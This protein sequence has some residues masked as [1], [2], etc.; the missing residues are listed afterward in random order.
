MSTGRNS[1][2]PCGSGLKYK[3]C[4]GPKEKTG[5]GSQILMAAAFLIFG[6]LVVAAVFVS[7][8][9]SG[10]TSSVPVVPGNPGAQQPGPAPPGKVWS[11][12]HGHWHDAADQPGGAASQGQSQ[13]G[14]AQP[15]GPAPEG[16]VWSA[17]H[18]HWHDAK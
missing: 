6:G 12:E 14:S 9:D 4:C 11:T 3:R 2:C 13:P 15:P 8:D 1:D 10:P 5:K 17:E 7:R 16:K 18:G